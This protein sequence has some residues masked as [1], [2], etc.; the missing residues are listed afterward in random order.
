MQ[1]FSVEDFSESGTNKSY[2]FAEEQPYKYVKIVI[3]SYKEKDGEKLLPQMNADIQ[4]CY[5]KHKT[6][7]YFVNHIDYWKRQNDRY[8]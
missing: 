7:L 1:V 2:V 3:E 6:N 8:H 5:G 4:C